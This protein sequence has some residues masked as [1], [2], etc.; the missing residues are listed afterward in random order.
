[1]QKVSLKDMKGIVKKTH[2]LLLDTGH[3]L[4]IMIHGPAGVGKSDSIR[5]VAKDLGIK[6][7]DIRLS[8]LNPVDLRG[9][10]SIN[11]KE[12]IAEWIPSGFLPD[13]KRDGEE[14]ILFLDE[15]NLAPM[16]VMNA[17]Y[18]LILDRA[19]GEYKLP[20]KWSII[21]AGNRTEDTG[22]ITKMPAPLANRFIHYEM[23]KPD[24]D[25]WRTWAIQNNIAAQV[26]SFIHKFPQHLLQMPKN[27]EKTF[28][29]PRSWGYA[30]DLFSIGEPIDA[31]V[32][33]GVATDFKAYIEVYTKVPDIQKILKG[34]KERVPE[35][36]ELDVLWATSMAIV[37]AAKPEH[38]ANVFKYVNQFSPE[39][40]TMVIK[41]LSDKSPEWFNVIA[42][43]DDFKKFRSAHP[44]LFEKDSDGE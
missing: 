2:R 38:W 10:P 17:G 6:C 32:G 26:I 18:Q 9:L 19:L 43:S 4:P 34:E 21:A 22:N 8:L 25:E 5:Q 14:G 20:A 42:H 39:F 37:V 12:G 3:S 36:K 16:T 11:R 27:A 23:D 44:A 24:Q 41:L 29:S 31:A 30:S 13:A 7:I 15:I 28:P 35:K 33:G 40:S 1:M